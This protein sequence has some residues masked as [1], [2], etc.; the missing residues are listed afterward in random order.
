MDPNFQSGPNFVG[1]LRDIA[2]ANHAHTA[3]HT[4]LRLEG[5]NEEIAG[6][7]KEA[8]IVS[9][10]VGLQSCNPRR[11]RRSTGASTGRRSN[12]VQSFC[13]SKRS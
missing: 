12:A 4:E 3:I 9:V 11:L 5:I 6:L 8:G 7:L 10:E 13:K 2:Y 1:R